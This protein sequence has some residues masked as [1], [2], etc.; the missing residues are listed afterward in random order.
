MQWFYNLKIKSKLLV[1]YTLMAIIVLVVGYIAV[2]KMQTVDERDGILYEKSTLALGELGRISTS[3]QKVRV[4][5]AKIAILE[6]QSESSGTSSSGISS[7]VDGYEQKIDVRREEIQKNLKLFEA[8]LMDGN[9]K[10]EYQSLVSK[11]DDW[12]MKLDVYFSLIKDKKISEANALFN[13]DLQSFVEKVEIQLDSMM[14]DEEAIAKET[15]DE[16]TRI[17]ESAR[18]MLL[19]LIV[20]GLLT[21]LGLGV[22]MSNIINNPVKK[23]YEISLELAKGHV[24]ARA[25]IESEDEIGLMAKSFDQVAQRLQTMAEAMHE[26]AAGNVN[27]SVPV[28]DG[29][30]ALAPALN[31]IS[32][33]LRDLVEEANMLSKAGIE[34]RLS[35]RGNEQKFKGGYRDIVAGVNAT[36][37]AVISPVKEGSDVLAILAT[38][39]LTARVTREFSGDHQIIKN[40]INNLADSFSSAITEVSSAVQAAASAA[41]QISSS[42]E[43][44]AAGAQEQSSQASEIASAVEEMTKT[45]LESSQ[46]T[47]VAAEKSKLASESTMSGERKIEETKQGMIRIVDATMETGKIITSLAKK[48]DQIGEITQV[49]DEI[50]DQTN[51][52]ALNAAIE[53][54]RAGEQGRGF[55]VVADEVRKLAERTTKATKEIADTIKTVQ[56]EAKEADYSMKEAGKSVQ[57]GM[58]LTEEVAKALIQIREMNIIVADLVNQV[59]ATSEEQSTTAEQISKNI[60][61]I[62]S[63]T[64]ESAAGTGQIARAAEDLSRLTENLQSLVGR[65]HLDTGNN[66]GMQTRAPQQTTRMSNRFLSN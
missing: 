19:S 10:K 64:Q 4:Y 28:I 60:E 1:S 5:S 42:S 41:T 66:R 24:K 26:I 12:R 22:F 11:M 46:N 47:G 51:L 62:S 6:Q 55:A 23:V 54:A 65:F 61:N 32:S 17:Y 29:E 34:G 58:A 38:G 49:I 15:S 30:D 37:D 8:T 14:K 36:L 40:S 21:A 3:F 35:T 25:N 7:A 16:N 50:A 43:E 56:K 59:A 18:G 13:G 44:M 45:I 33:T 48:T 20:I 52:L 39:D 63:V 57:A 31:G 2:T 9:D 27:I 53:A